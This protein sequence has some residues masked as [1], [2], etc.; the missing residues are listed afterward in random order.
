MSKP[1]GPLAIHGNWLPMRFVCFHNVPQDP[2]ACFCLPVVM[3]RSHHQK[4]TAESNRA[5]TR[6][7]T[8]IY[9]Y[10][11]MG[12]AQ[13]STGGATRRFWSMFRLTR[14]THFGYVFLI[15][16]QPYRCAFLMSLFQLSGTQHKSNLRKT[17]SKNNNI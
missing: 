9:I 17:K 11:Y 2:H 8:Y 7:Y 3:L 15:E 1:K 6:T 4:R 14:A 16:P 10:V 12:V 13:N 5:H